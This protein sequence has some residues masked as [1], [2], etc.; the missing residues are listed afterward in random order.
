MTC[1]LSCQHS[2]KPNHKAKRL[3]INICLKFITWVTYRLQYY[4]AWHIGCRTL[5]SVCFAKKS[6][7]ALLERL[8]SSPLRADFRPKFSCIYLQKTSAN[9][10]K[11][12]SQL[13]H[14]KTRNRRQWDWARMLSR[15]ALRELH[16]K[17]EEFRF[18][19][20]N[21]RIART[22]AEQIELQQ[23][24]CSFQLRW[25]FLISYFISF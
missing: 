19:L 3:Q 13:Q 22:L 18:L 17:F 15:H 8:W 23:A 9:V 20:F 1:K 10:N 24:L 14:C 2:T 6:S 21:Q 25:W 12:H 4:E 11:K 5:A 7:G 16:Q